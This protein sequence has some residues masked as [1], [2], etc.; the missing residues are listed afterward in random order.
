MVEQLD[1]FLEESKQN[2]IELTSTQ[3]EILDNLFLAFDANITTLYKMFPSASFKGK[4]PLN[5]FK[6]Y[7]STSDSLI[8]LAS[9]TWNLNIN[10]IQGFNQ[11]NTFTDDLLKELEP[12]GNMIAEVKLPV[13]VPEFE[14]TIVGKYKLEDSW[15]LTQEGLKAVRSIHRP[16]CSLIMTAT[17]LFTRFNMTDN[18]VEKAFQFSSN[19]LAELIWQEGFEGINTDK[20]IE[21]K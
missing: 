15:V 17:S 3:C 16:S 4:K 8:E 5:N 21:F 13:F 2:Q 9:Y 7:K 12:A 10:N 14:G 11:A 1:K 18:I 6:N 20:Q 19:N